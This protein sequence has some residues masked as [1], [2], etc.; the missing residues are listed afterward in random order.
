M[1]KNDILKQLLDM[2][3]KIDIIV[4]KMYSD[5]CSND[6]QIEALEDLKRS[7]RYSILEISK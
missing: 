6:S 7:I 3:Q 5:E 4:D 1:K 2:K